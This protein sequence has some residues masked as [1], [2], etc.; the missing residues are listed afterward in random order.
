MRTCEFMKNLPSSNARNFSALSK[1]SQ[2]MGGRPT[3]VYNVNVSPGEKRIVTEKQPLLLRY[4]NK[5]WTEDTN[6]SSTRQGRKRTSGASNAEN[7]PST[8][9]CLKARKEE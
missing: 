5:T 7:D 6:T 9:G 1:E 8:S 2:R 4:L 3:V